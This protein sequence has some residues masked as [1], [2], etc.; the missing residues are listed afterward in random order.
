MCTCTDLP[1]D[2]FTIIESLSRSITAFRKGEGSVTN[3]RV[4]WSSGVAG[5]PKV[6]RVHAKAALLGREQQ[7]AYGKVTASLVSE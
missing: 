2:F 7:T 3:D 1:I 5:V 4:A 6:E